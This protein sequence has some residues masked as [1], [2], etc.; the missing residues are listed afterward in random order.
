MKLEDILAEW[1]ET[2]SGYD[3]DDIDN[4]LRR[5]PILHQKYQQYLNAYE[6]RTKSRQQ[7]LDRVYAERYN[8]YRGRS[9]DPYPI[10]ITSQ[11]EADIY[12][13]ADPLYQ[14]ADAALETAKMATRRIKEIL[15]QI[16][17]RGFSLKHHIEWKRFVSGG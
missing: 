7:E 13:K 5:L 9:Q 11:S 17:G 1:N 12:I 14:Q 15:D 10:K 4:E 8:H 3:D 2:D 16:K 6:A